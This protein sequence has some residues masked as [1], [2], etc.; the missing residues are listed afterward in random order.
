M[1]PETGRES[2]NEI[3]GEICFHFS[4]NNTPTLP[5]NR[6]MIQYEMLIVCLRYQRA[7]DVQ[8]TLRSRWGFF[9]SLF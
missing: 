1:T 5:L 4:G 9:L 2:Q 7:V 6:R 8:A 3:G